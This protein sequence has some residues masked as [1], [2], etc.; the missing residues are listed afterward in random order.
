[1]VETT[2]PQP[3]AEAALATVKAELA[4]AHVSPDVTRK[5]LGVVQAALAE[6]RHF[7]T[8]LVDSLPVGLYA[9]DREYRVQAWNRKRETG[10]Q[11]IARGEALGR[12]I[13]EILH[14]QPA[15]SLK[16][17]I[18]RVFTTGQLEQFET[19]LRWLA[20]VEAGLA[21]RGKAKHVPRPS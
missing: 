13:F 19:E 7:L 16:T 4:S 21:R 1:M 14:R 20:S 11:G 17:E 18:D 12:T 2:A 15:E 6:Q 5:V 9:V 3:I 8:A 10:M